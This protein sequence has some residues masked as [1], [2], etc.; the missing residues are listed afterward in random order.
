MKKALNQE[1]IDALFS[2]AGAKKRVITPCDFRRSGQISKDHLRAL[3]IEQQRASASGVPRE[4][5]EI[6]LRDRQ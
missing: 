5:H 4:C 3:T 6:E 2:Q 1:E